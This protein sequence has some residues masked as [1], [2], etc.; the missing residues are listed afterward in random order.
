MIDMEQIKEAALVLAAAA[1]AF[2]AAE[3]RLGKLL[4][5]AGAPLTVLTSVPQPSAYVDDENE[6]TSVLAPAVKSKAERRGRPPGAPTK[7]KAVTESDDAPP[8][9]RAKTADK[10]LA[11]LEDGP[12]WFGE[13]LT[14]SG[15]PKSSVYGGL[16]QLQRAGRIVQT[17]EKKWGIA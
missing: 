8:L 4:A 15:M 11:A 12:L 2:K 6:G 13:I 3:D 17:S 1:D 16:A 10:V 14:K 7:V 5:S 9:S